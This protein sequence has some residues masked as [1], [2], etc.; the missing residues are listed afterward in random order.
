MCSRETIRGIAGIT[1]LIIYIIFLCL[2]VTTANAFY[3]IMLITSTLQI[4]ACFCYYKTSYNEY[5]RF[6]FF[7]PDKKADCCSEILDLCSCG[8]L[9]FIE[10]VAYGE[11]SYMLSLVFV[12]AF[13]YFI[14]RILSDKKSAAVVPS[15]LPQTVVA[16]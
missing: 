12:F 7:L 5:K 16:P 10:G 13:I 8:Y 6:L 14:I 3:I 4:L 2:A 11:A 9:G 15:D 1:Y